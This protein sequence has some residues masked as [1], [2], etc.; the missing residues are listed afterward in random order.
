VSLD[1]IE[2]M[3]CVVFDQS[4]E[5]EGA[6][7]E[8]GRKVFL[9]SEL[10][11]TDSDVVHDSKIAELFAKAC[12][13][14]GESIFA[15]ELGR[16]ADE[17]YNRVARAHFAGLTDEERQTPTPCVHKEFRGV[18]FVASGYDFWF[19]K[20]HL[21]L[22]ECAAIAL[23]DNFNASIGG[24]AFHKS[25]TTEVLPPRT[26]EAEWIPQFLSKWRNTAMA[27]SAVGTLDKG[28]FFPPSETAGS[29]CCPF[30]SFAR[31][32]ATRCEDIV[33]YFERAQQF[34]QRR[35]FAA[36][37]FVMGQEIFLD[38]ERFVVESGRIHVLSEQQ[39]APVNF[40][41]CWNFG[42]D[43]SNYVDVA[44]TVEVLQPLVPPIL[45]AETADCFHLMFDF[46][47]NAWMVKPQQ[48][49]VPIPRISDINPGLAEENGKTPWLSAAKRANVERGKKGAD[50]P[51]WGE[52]SSGVMAE[53]YPGKGKTSSGQ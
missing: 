6:A 12:Y 4:F 26:G 17:C 10:I 31:F 1:E 16:F 14:T 48:Y 29:A 43:P 18:H 50:G 23:L 42:G 21:T 2:A 30:H 46:F 19:P 35:V 37:I 51:W 5:H 49:E 45:Y 33:E 41:A 27:D 11:F 20:G 25:C 36:P 32:D 47:R 44:Q 38:A 24:S 8:D 13:L 22:Q 9:R 7:Y 52:T 3:T 34:A 53:L 15:P 28:N 40:A 39:L